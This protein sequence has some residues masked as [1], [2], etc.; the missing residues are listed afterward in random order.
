LKA[1]LSGMVRFYLASSTDTAAPFQQYFVLP[2]IYHIMMFIKKI[3]CQGKGTANAA[4]GK[5][6]A[7]EDVIKL[8]AATDNQSPVKQN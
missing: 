4:I 5:E 8:C 2:T 1:D 6:G 7:D 3:S